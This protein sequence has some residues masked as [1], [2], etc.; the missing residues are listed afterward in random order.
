[1][2]KAQAIREAAF[3]RELSKKHFTVA[4]FGSARIQEN[5]P[6]YMQVELLAQSI[7][8]RGYDVVTGGG[9]GI[10]EAANKGHREG[11][12]N[13]HVHSLG[14]NIKLPMEQPV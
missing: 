1:M 9:P 7:G 2:T 8:S 6:I 5:N 4:I 14:L 10:M 3:G 13:H 11:R 12:N